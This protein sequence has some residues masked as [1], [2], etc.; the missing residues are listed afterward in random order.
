MTYKPKI[1][2][3]HLKVVSQREK[4]GNRKS[5]TSD[6]FDRNIRTF[7]AKPRH[8]CPKKSDVFHFRNR[9]G[10]WCLG[11]P[12]IF[13]PRGQNRPPLITDIKSRGCTPVGM[14]CLHTYNIMLCLVAV[15][16]K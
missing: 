11:V 2:G 10:T 16:V 8:F 4:V 9:G 14:F 6:F 12:F 7:E 13:K 3:E 5:K 1:M 15:V